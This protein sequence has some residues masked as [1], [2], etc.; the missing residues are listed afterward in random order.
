MISRAHPFL[1]WALVISVLLHALLISAPAWRIEPAMQDRLTVALRRLP[2]PQEPPAKPPLVLPPPL[3][4]LSKPLV[5]MA[6]PAPTP[7]PTPTPSPPARQTVSLQRLSGEAARVAG[8]QMARELLYP[9]AAIERGQ[10]GEAL[11][12]LFLDDSGNAVAARLEESSGHPLLDDA[13]LRAARTLRALPASAPR[14]ALL[15]VRFRLR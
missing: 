6:A 5:P 8:E 11:V 4:R 9:L 13:A 3:P 15:P 10:Q 2:A 12:L 14:E 1:G 7:T